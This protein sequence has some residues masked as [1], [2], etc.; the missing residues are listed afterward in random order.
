MENEVYEE[1]RKQKIEKFRSKEQ[2]QKILEYLK[3]GLTCDE[4]SNMSDIKLKRSTIEVYKSTCLNYNLISENEIK[5]ARKQRKKEELMQNEQVKK[6]L[7]YREQN[8]SSREIANMPDITISQK[9]VLNYINKCVEYGI[10]PENSI[11][12]IEKREGKESFENNEQVQRA[13]EYLRQGKKCNEISEM[14]DI[15]VSRNTVFNWKR[16]AIKYGLIDE[17]QIDDKKENKK[18]EDFI[19]NEQVKKVIEY[20]RQGLSDK[21]IVKKQ[22]I[23]VSLSTIVSY[24]NKAIEQ[25]LITKEEIKEAKRKKQKEREKENKA[26]EVEEKSK[27]KIEKFKENEQIQRI[28]AYARQG[29]SVYRI[30][31]MP[32]ITVSKPTIA[33]YIDK[34]IEYGMITREEIVES[35]EKLQ[36]EMEKE[37]R[38]IEEKKQKEREETRRKREEQREEQ[39]RKKE[40]E[41]IK[42]EEERRKREEQ[43]EEER[44]K[45]EEE[46]TKREK[47]RRKREEQREEER[48][49]KE[50][51]RQKREEEKERTR[52]QREEEREEAK[53]KQKEQEKRERIKREENKKQ[54]FIASEQV[55]KIIAYKK[56]GISDNQIATMPDITISISTVKNYKNKC[57]EY[58]LISR[59]EI[60]EARRSKKTNKLIQKERIIKEERKESLQSVEQKR[61]KITSPIEQ[62]RRKIT[63]PIEQ[64]RRKEVSQIEQKEEDPEKRLRRLR[65]E[66]DV[67]VKINKRPSKDKEG[68]IR[69]YIEQFYEINQDKSISKSDLIFLKN[70]LKKININYRD[71]VRYTKNCISSKKYNEAIELYN[72]A[73]NERTTLSAEETKK[74]NL[75]AYMLKRADAVQRVEFAMSRGNSNTMTLAETTGLSSEEI[76]FL[77]IKLLKQ[78][79]KI[80]GVKRREQILQMLLK[81]VDSD[82]LQEKLQISDLEME[83]MKNQK[84]YRRIKP[85]KRDTQAQ[86]KQNSTIRIETLFTKLGQSVEKI[87]SIL[88]QDPNEVRK[89]IELAL[90]V[91]LIKENQL[92][93]ID[94]LRLPQLA[95]KELEL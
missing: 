13:L 24:K 36:K 29:L 18:I 37:R 10:I 20:K 35:K 83:D 68:K 6:I 69:D 4:I 62:K 26:K 74:I 42:K 22:D 30:V 82:K 64:K 52:K 8:L 44:R 91:G 84:E 9:T 65:R 72:M 75:L 41:M 39:I 58:G 12:H 55:Q 32:D 45:K 27:K 80:S 90:Q 88:K 40:E 50:E 7:S 81:G 71:I 66:I 53:K 34:C 43:R 89:D 25:G 21:E 49:K 17:K 70:A 95:L 94:L 57:I 92:N 60:E 3:Q 54:E 28:I 77:K 86:I 11:N 33:N 2:I 46:R 87:A 61:R 16:K 56:Q 79:V 31:A 38:K 48:R 51:E 47:E 85:E 23:S 59:E 63:S 93:G 67:D 14:P 15:T 19:S 78:K 1:E 5:E 73:L 76:N